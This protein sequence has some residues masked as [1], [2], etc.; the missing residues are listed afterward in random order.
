MFCNSCSAELPDNDRFCPKCGKLLA[1]EPVQQKVSRPTG[2]TILAVLQLIAGIFFV[3][4]AIGIG[5]IST[6]EGMPTLVQ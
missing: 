1:P 5:V 2:I 4:A 6:R 3:I